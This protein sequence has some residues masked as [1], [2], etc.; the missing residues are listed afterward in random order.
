[1]DYRYLVEC[2]RKDQVRIQPDTS[3]LFLFWVRISI[4]LVTIRYIVT[5][6]SEYGRVNRSIF[7][8]TA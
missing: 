7:L 5:I 4:L 2:R 1:M 8:L 6:S 3:F